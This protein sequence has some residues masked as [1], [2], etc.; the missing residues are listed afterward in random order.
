MKVRSNVYAEV[1]ANVYVGFFFVVFAKRCT[2]LPP[3]TYAIDAKHCVKFCAQH[4]RDSFRETSRSFARN[5]CVRVREATSR[6][7]SNES[8][9]A[10]CNQ[11]Q[12]VHLPENFGGN[13]S[14]I[15]AQDSVE[16]CVDV[17]RRNSL[18]KIFPLKFARLIA[19]KFTWKST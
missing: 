18:R 4:L 11:S 13:S 8:S 12:C 19:R 9:D 3:K 14:G 15:C 16:V 17:L 5:V 1:R 10:S 6:T 2:R 7:N